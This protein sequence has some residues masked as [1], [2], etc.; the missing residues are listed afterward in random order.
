MSKPIT[1]EQAIAAT[2]KHRESTVR[3]GMSPIDGRSERCVKCRQLR[4]AH[5]TKTCP[6][7]QTM[8]LPQNITCADCIHVDRCC[9]IFGQL[10]E[11]ERCQFFPMR[12]RHAGSATAAGDRQ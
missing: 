6:E 9:L 11:D 7:W 8:N 10:P 12:F 1:R 3:I 2:R 5:P 4:E